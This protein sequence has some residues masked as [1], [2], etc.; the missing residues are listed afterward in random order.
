[1]FGGSVF[2]RS[3]L[4]SLMV[5]EWVCVQLLH[6]LGGIDVVGYLLVL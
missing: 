2:L 6:W 1:M 4:F 3:S 5:V